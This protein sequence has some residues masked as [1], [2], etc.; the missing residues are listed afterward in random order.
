MRLA[1]VRLDGRDQLAIEPSAGVLITVQDAVKFGGKARAF[2]PE[3]MLALIRS[4]LQWLDTLQNAVSA[5]RASDSRIRRYRLDE[6]QWYAPVRS[7]S[8]IV[9]VALNNRALDAVKIRAPSD[10][11]AF[12]LK[13]STALIGHRGAIRLRAAYGLTHP[14]PELGVVI[15]QTLRDASPATAMSA[16]FGYTIVNDVTCVGMREEDSFT[17]RVFK[18]GP[19]PGEVSVG[20]AHTTYPGRYKGSD[21]FAPMGPYLVTRDEIPDAAA[22]QITCSLGDRM[23]ASDHTRNYVWDVPHALSHISR[24]MTLLP[25][26]I[27]SMGTAV[28]GGAD[29]ASAGVPGLTRADLI[30]FEGI[31]S[32]SIAGLGT[33][34]NRVETIREETGAGGDERA[35]FST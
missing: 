29:S 12:F 4:G 18:P 17:V 1:S 14:E 19:T 9:C 23:V 22:L 15:G 31:V 20:E 35:H 26:D 30:G 2:E 21:T 7:P 33:L 34:E 24:T 16:I 27:V 13:P 8:K 11:P 10:H 3:D 6:A 5:A 28:G 25:G 32:I